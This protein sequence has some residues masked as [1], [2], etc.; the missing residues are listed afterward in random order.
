MYASTIYPS[1]YSKDNKSDQI[2][3]LCVGII[4]GS[5]ICICFM[6]LIIILL[7]RNETSSGSY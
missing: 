6:V 5:L 1:S 2:Y 4:W 3:N 7:V